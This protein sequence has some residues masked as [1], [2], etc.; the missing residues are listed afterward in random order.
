MNSIAAGGL[1]GGLL[2]LRMGPATAGVS[3]VFGAVV[4][5]MIEGMGI[6]MNRVMVAQSDKSQI[7]PPPREP[8]FA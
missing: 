5:A 4:L 1:T 8:M 6:L 2:C 7:E 3:A